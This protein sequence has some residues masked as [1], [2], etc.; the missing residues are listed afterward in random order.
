MAT[1]ALFALL[2]LSYIDKQLHRAV[3][4]I[5]AWVIFQAGKDDMIKVI[6]I[7]KGTNVAKKVLEDETKDV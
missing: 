5:L 3:Y 6:E 1:L 4:S 2:Y 7:I